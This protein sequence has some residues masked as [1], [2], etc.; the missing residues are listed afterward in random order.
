MKEHQRLSGL[1]DL[2]EDWYLAQP[3]GDRGARRGKGWTGQ[4]GFAAAMMVMLGAFTVIEGLAGLLADGFYLVA[5]EAVL[6]FDLTGWGWVHTIVGVLV[7]GTGLAL[8]SGAV[9]ARVGTVVLLILNAAAQLAFLAVSPLW[10]LI[11]IVLCVVVI[12]AVLVHDEEAG[13]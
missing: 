10:S 1:D 12:W 5:P 6:A 9:W 11:V 4:R 2:D 3:A 13:G 8:P 7:V